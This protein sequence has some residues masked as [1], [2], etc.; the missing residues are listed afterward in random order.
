MPCEL[1]CMRTACHA[2]HPHVGRVLPRRNCERLSRVR[3]QAGALS[4]PYEVA[5]TRS[6]SAMRA[7]MHAHGLQRTL[8]SAGSCPVRSVSAVR[9][10]MH[11]RKQLGRLLSLH[12]HAQAAWV[13][14]ELACVR[15]ACHAPPRLPQAPHQ[16]HG[17]L[18]EARA[19]AQPMRPCA[20][21]ELL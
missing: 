20:G 4:A 6:T 9:A 19:C 5:S 14:C 13:P 12:A 1:A 7:R 21:H 18:R 2:T 8:M 3:A 10:C 17:C 11:K 15:T 16:Q